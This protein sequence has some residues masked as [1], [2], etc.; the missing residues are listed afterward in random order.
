LTSL[1]MLQTPRLELIQLS[2]E[3]LTLYLDGNAEIT[4][5]NGQVS[6]E[7]LSNDLCRAINIKSK[8][9]SGMDPGDHA[10]ITYWLIHHRIDAYGI[11]MLGFKGVP[12]YR[13]QVE[14]GYG[15]D[16]SYSNQGL[17]TEAAARLIQW[18]FEEPL[19]LR[20]IAPGT[21]VD[22]PASNRVLEKLGMR[23]Y[24]E[25][26]ETLSWSLDRSSYSGSI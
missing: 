3:Q 21:R 13:G 20:I 1:T 2:Q 23:V 24:K 12:D 26:E 19:C 6:R 25:S 5:V 18:A 10:W 16:P 7:I 8:K 14:I 22:N 17:T 15:I 9:M 11:G 4:G